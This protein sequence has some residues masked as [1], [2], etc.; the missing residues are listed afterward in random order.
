MLA[1][2]VLF[3]L[4]G[5]CSGQVNRCGK[6]SEVV[7][8]F[9]HIF[10]AAGSS[11]RTLL[12][13][14]AEKCERKWV[15]LIE[16]S[17]GGAEKNGV[18]QCRLRDTVNVGRQALFSRAPGRHSKLRRNPSAELVGLEAEVIGGHYY[19]GMHGILAPGRS[20]A[21]FTVLREPVA[22]WISGIRY[23]DRA[24]RSVESVAAAAAA[25]LPPTASKQKY[26]NAMSY[27]VPA[28]QRRGVSARVKLEIS[29]TN[30]RDF[31]VVGLVESW[32]ATV[33]ALAAV[34]DADLAIPSFWD[35][36]KSLSRN[37]A[38]G[39]FGGRDVVSILR[40]DETLWGRVRAF[41]DVETRLYA[42]A[43]ARHAHTCRQVL[44]DKCPLERTVFLR[45]LNASLL[46]PDI[47]PS[48]ALADAMRRDATRRDE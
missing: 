4:V 18:V 47:L 46:A 15:C 25:S 38:S 6:E 28:D 29:R 13:R 3:V 7:L 9:V 12:R 17:E 5:G 19:Y 14:Y 34:L 8:L 35:R 27:L 39:Q 1:L 23:H 24:L 32:S 2:L 20:Y 31:R 22:T 48:R 41:L 44:G 21:Y 36:H 33:D 37:T 16:C 40:R 30:L 26:A 10:K 11:V 45:S 43:I 42:D